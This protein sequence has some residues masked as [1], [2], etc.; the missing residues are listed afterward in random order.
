MSVVT[1]GLDPAYD[2]AVGPGR[3]AEIGAFVADRRRVAIVSQAGI[4][5]RYG[6]VVRASITAPSEVF[7][8]G[9]GEHAK[10]L[11]T[12]EDLCRGFARW[13]LLRGDVVVALGGGVVGDTAGFAAASYHRGISIVQA[14][15]TL[16]A[17]VDAAIGGKTAVNLPEG[18]NLV[19]AFHQPIRVVADTDTL[20]SLPPREFRS[21]LG[22]VA[23]YALMYDVVADPT[24]LVDVLRTGTTAILDRDPTVLGDV[25]ERCV[26]IKAEVVAADPFERSGL[27]AQ[28]NLGHTLAH[29]LEI[30]YE[31]RLTH[32]EAVAIGLVFAGALAGGCERVGTDVV[33][34][35]QAIPA[36]LGLPTDV[37]DPE[38]AT[39][40]GLLDLMARDKKASGGL[41][42]VLPGP[43]GLELVEDPPAAALR[44]A[45]ES[46]GITGEDAIT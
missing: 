29:A 35:F 27:R 18:K 8:M 17:M 26:R 44:Y 10:S 32:G 11:T 21:G 36:S 4:A 46:V 22:E 15:T 13:G 25:V 5:E 9:D 14:P 1:V 39:A 30:A 34:R 43:D 3:L 24:G 28:L 41:T 12:I 16:L 19:G 2:V 45:F 38:S 40:A 33:D 37:P 31:H 42:F 6:D 23:K 7:L 20:Q